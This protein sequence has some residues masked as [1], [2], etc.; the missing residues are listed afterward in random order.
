MNHV[1]CGYPMPR[2]PEFEDV[3]ATLKKTAAAL[4]NAGV[5][6]MLG[7]GLAAWV[8]GGP[9][10]DH[11]LDYMV[12]PTDAGRALAALVQAGLRPERPPERWLLK[13]WD[14]DVLVDL[15]FRPASGTVGDDEFE[16]AEVIEV[17]AQEMPVMSLEDVVVTKLLALREHQVDYDSVLEIA[18]SLREQIDWDDVRTRTAESPYAKAFFVL[19]EELA[20]IEA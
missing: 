9:E 20:I 14:G 6:F 5:P 7:G 3:C 8:R 2:M 18:R 4:E 11:D 15:I 1:P 16:R 17:L 10:S 13:A 19:A 12:R